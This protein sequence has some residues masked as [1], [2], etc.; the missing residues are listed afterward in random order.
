MVYC[1][2]SGGSQNLLIQLAGIVRRD[3]AHIVDQPLPCIP[4]STRPSRSLSGTPKVLRLVGMSR[5]DDLFQLGDDPLCLF[6]HGGAG[7]F[8]VAAAVIGDSQTL[9]NGGVSGVKAHD[10]CKQN[11]VGNAVGNVVLTAQRIAQSVDGKVV[12]LAVMARPP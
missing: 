5:C 6:V 9:L 1:S 4:D 2:L 8:L 12:P 7:L 10:R 11:G 3:R